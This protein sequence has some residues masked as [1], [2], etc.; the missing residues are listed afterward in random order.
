MST[1]RTVGETLK[2]LEHLSLKQAVLDEVNEYLAQFIATDSYE[3]TKGISSPLSADVIPQEV[4]EEV[5]DELTVKRVE[6]ETKIQEL[7]GQPVSAAAKAVRKKAPAKK[8]TRKAPPK[9]RKTSAKGKQQ[10][11]SA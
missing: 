7:K 4:I 3:P 1:K 2:E 10:A 11:K 9:R 8:A 5:K 6:Y